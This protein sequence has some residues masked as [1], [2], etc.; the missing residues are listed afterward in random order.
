MARGHLREGNMTVRL[1]M[2]VA[3]IELPTIA[4]INAQVVVRLMRKPGTVVQ[5]ETREWITDAGT[6]ARMASIRIADGTEAARMCSG[7]Q[8]AIRRHKLNNAE[9]MVDAVRDS[10]RQS[11]KII[12]A[13]WL[14]RHHVRLRVIKPLTKHLNSAQ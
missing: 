11:K 5:T 8:N 7:Q 2:T 14:E 12:V 1:V 10:A 13:R 9:Q 6:G 4:P 3:H